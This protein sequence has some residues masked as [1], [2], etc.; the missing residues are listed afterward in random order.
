VTDSAGSPAT[1]DS[2]EVHIKT[3]PADHHT[4][5]FAVV[6]DSIINGF[7]NQSGA[8]P[9]TPLL[10][11][12]GGKAQIT[13]G[14]TVANNRAVSG[15]TSLD[16]Q[17]GGSLLPNVV[18]DIAGQGCNVAIILLGTNDAKT[19]VAT[20]SSTYLARMT[21]ILDALVAAGVRAFVSYPPFLDWTIAPGAA[22]DSTV[23]TFLTGYMAQLDS[24]HNGTTIFRIGNSPNLHTTTQ[25]AEGTYLQA[26]GTHL[27]SS[28]VSLFGTD[29]ANQI[30]SDL[31]PSGAASRVSQHLAM[32]VRMG[33]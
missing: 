7:F 16:W 31:F 30:Y 17:L 29:W 3:Q 18:A 9:L 12:L 20:S 26:D 21:A 11:T 14:A 13:G 23:D 1:A 15:T 33:L 10:S 32:A 19:S 27:T 4:L 24:L 28:G 2:N 25:A 8:T 22:W 5:V 6:G